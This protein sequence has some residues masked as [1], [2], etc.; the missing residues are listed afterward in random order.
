[1]DCDAG[2]EP[3]NDAG[4]RA[5]GGFMHRVLIADDMAP[6]SNLKSE[7]EVIAHY[8]K[9]YPNTDFAV[10]CAF[11]YRLIKLLRSQGYQVDPANTPAEALRLAAAKSYNVIVLDL[12]WW[13]QKKGDDK[14][15]VLGFQIADNMRARSPA[16]IL[17]FSNRF[18]DDEALARTAAEKG[19]LPVYKSYDDVGAKSLLV[20][21]RWAVLRKTVAATV[22]DQGKFISLR[23][24]RRLSN[25]LLGSIIS[26]VA[27]LFVAVALAVFKRTSARMVASVFGTVT[28]FVN[29]AIYRFVSEYRKSM[30]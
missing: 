28:T 21:I 16:Q 9:L 2:L 13:T 4:G 5:G 12:G 11:M 3:E 29:G 25:V 23:M 22:R 18:F 30:G 27:L 15:M 14:K 1:V 17:M 10:G 26:A 20:T 7:Q 6:D 19:C 8:S 24:Y